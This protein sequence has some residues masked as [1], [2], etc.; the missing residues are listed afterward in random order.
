[1]YVFKLSERCKQRVVVISGSIDIEFHIVKKIPPAE[2]QNG[3]HIDIDSI[4]AD[5]FKSA[6][7]EYFLSLFLLL[8]QIY[9]IF[10]V[11]KIGD[12]RII[13]ELDVNEL[14][15]LLLNPV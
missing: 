3:P 6:N 5:I 15:T 10:A 4:F 13:V 12:N 14:L 2:L 8:F 9:K 11:H 7:K 1:M